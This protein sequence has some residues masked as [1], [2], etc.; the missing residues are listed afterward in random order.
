MDQKPSGFTKYLWFPKHLDCTNHLK[1]CGSD[2]KHMLDAVWAD[3]SC[4]GLWNDR[5][6][7]NFGE[8]IKIMNHNPLKNL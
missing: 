8:I 1:I 4:T 3:R 2:I 7:N 5:D 6:E